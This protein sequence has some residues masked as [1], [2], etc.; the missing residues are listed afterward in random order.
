LAKFADAGVIGLLFGAG[1]GGSTT[2]Y[3]DTWTDGQL[4]LKSRT[5]ALQSTGGF[6]LP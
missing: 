6:T 2:P 3:N 5:D 1:D 4:F